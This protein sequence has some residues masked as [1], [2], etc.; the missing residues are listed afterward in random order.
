MDELFGGLSI[1]TKKYINFMVDRAVE[2]GMKDPKKGA[3]ALMEIRNMLDTEEERDFADFS[4][5][6]AKLERGTYNE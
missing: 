1:H 2:K 6:I 3:E 5:E 4:Y